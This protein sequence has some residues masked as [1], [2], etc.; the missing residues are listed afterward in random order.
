MSDAQLEYVFDVNLRAAHNLT[1]AVIP[2]LTEE[3]RNME[4]KKI[5]NVTSITGITGNFGQTNYAMAK[6]GMIGYTKACARELARHRVNVNAIA[7]GFTE[8]Q[9][10]QIKRSGSP[11][12]MPEAFRNF[13]IESTPFARNGHAGQPHHIGN[14][15]LFLASRLSDWM[16]GQVFTVGGGTYI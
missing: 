2:Y 13:C 10:T 14:V 9:M 15:I 16:T 6:A 12:G 5:V 11:L 4:F 8:T 7:P 3:S 1:K